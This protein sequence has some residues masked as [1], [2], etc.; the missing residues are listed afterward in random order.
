MVIALESDQGLIDVV[1][2]DRDITAGSI[3]ITTSGFS[4][5]AIPLWVSLLNYTAYESRGFN[6]RDGFES[7]DIPA[8]S[9][10]GKLLIF[11]IETS[12]LFV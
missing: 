3:I 4:Y 12:R 10:D 11:V 1:E 6:L 7:A 2:G 5:G 9:A 8:N